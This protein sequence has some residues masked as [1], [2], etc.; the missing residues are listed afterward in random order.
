MRTEMGLDGKT[1][2][3]ESSPKKRY[4][5]TLEPSPNGNKR[6]AEQRD[7]Q[8]TNQ[9]ILQNAPDLKTGKKI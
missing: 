4:W 9:N 1:K 7:R 3:A 2:K 5:K 6:C 8:T